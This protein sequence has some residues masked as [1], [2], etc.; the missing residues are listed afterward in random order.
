MTK[1]YT[2][3]QRQI[4]K[5]Q[6]EAEAVKAKEVPRVVARIKVAIA[7]YGLKP[8]DLF[9]ASGAKTAKAPKVAKVSKAAKKA[10]ST[11]KYTDGSGNTWTGIGKRPRWFLAAI[12]GG[13]TPKDL[14]IAAPAA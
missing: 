9:P 14:E 6:K 8:D 12:E 11:P 1:T 3:L 4:A 10:P 5:L 7:H 13:K 2:Q